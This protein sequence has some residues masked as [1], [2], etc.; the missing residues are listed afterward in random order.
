MY[1]KFVFQLVSIVL[2]IWNIIGIFSFI[3][4][5]SMR[6][7]RLAA[8]P[9]EEQALYENFPLWVTIVFAIAVFTGVGGAIQLIR[10]DASSVQLFGISLIAVIIQMTYNLFFSQ[11]VAYYGSMS[12]IIPVLVILFAIFAFFYSKI[13][14][15]NID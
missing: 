9:E 14:F 12:V 8:L 3:A 10:K 13:Y 2:L 7:E 15:D 11:S 5:V 6:A 4:H 1:G